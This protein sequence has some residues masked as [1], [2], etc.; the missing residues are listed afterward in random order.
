MIPSLQTKEVRRERMEVK[1]K[2]RREEEKRRKEIGFRFTLD[3]ACD[4]DTGIITHNMFVSLINLNH[5]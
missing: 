5:N 2:I 1:E 3:E 4:Y